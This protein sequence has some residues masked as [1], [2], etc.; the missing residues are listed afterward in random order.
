MP[1]TAPHRSQ[2]QIGKTP[3]ELT[4]SLLSTSFPR[5]LKALN[6]RGSSPWARIGTR[7][8]AFVVGKGLDLGLL[9]GFISEH[10][11][12]WF[13]EDLLWP[14]NNPK[15]KHRPLL[16]L[17]GKPSQV[18]SGIFKVVP[19]QID[20]SVLKSLSG[21]A[22]SQLLSALRFMH[23]IDG[24]GI[25]SEGLKK[26]ADAVSTPE[27]STKLAEFLTEAYKPIIKGLDLKTATPKMLAESFKKFGGVEGGT[28]ELALRFF[29]IGMKEA[30]VEL[31][32]YWRCGSAPPVAQAFGVQVARNPNPPGRKQVRKNRSRRKACSRFRSR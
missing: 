31:S 8:C 2:K 27:W 14:T 16:I 10:H 7:T 9:K 3:I 22:R 26:L 17:H 6:F 13:S 28:V 19:A 30:G 5:S 24:D 32:P 18:S 1:R 12:R 15:Q 20:A 21:T 29:L 25:P 11:S 23:L 4:S